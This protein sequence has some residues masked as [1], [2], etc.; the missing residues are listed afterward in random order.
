VTVS[1][2]WKYIAK[3]SWSQARAPELTNIAAKAAEAMM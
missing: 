3:G 2:R 1:L